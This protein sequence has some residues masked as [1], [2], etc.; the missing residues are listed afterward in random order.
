M[1]DVRKIKM[2]GKDSKTADKHNPWELK[3]EK[4]FINSRRNLSKP[5]KIHQGQ[6]NPIQIKKIIPRSRKRYHDQ[7][8]FIK[9]KKVQ[10]KGIR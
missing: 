7:E 1:S 2:L 4:E 6:E 9:T 10:S 8:K 5:R 3:S